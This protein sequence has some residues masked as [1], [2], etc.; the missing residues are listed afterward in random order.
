VKLV[1]R[2]AKNAW[3]LKMAEGCNLGLLPGGV[4]NC[5]PVATWAFVTKPKRGADKWKG[6]NVKNVRSVDGELGQSPS[7]NANNFQKFYSELYNNDGTVGGKADEWHDVMP[8]TSNVREWRTPQV[9]ELLRAVRELKNAAPGL[10]GAPA[11]MWKAMIT[12]KR[13]Q[14]IMLTMMRGCWDAGTVPS[15]W[16]VHC[17]TVLEKKETWHSARI[18]VAQ[19]W[20]RHFR[21]YTPQS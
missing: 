2:R 16:L 12:D 7:D 19:A 17:M 11:T 15:E 13:L 6:W 1:K 5:N 9:H 8:Q 18:T 4:R 14:E 20:A 21:K 3:L 10:T